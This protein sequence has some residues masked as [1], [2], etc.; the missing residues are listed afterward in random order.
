MLR[1][2]ASPYLRTNVT[3]TASNISKTSKRL[4]NYR[5]KLKGLTGLNLVDKKKQ[6]DMALHAFINADPALK[7]NQPNHSNPVP[8][9][10]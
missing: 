3:L 4:P 6:E 2:N 10:T 1:K 7:P 9:N 8:I 5:G